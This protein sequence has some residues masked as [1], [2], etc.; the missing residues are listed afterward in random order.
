MSEGGQEKKEMS[1]MSPDL[2]MQR[3]QQP[4]GWHVGRELA[5]YVVSRRNYQPTGTERTFGGS[6]TASE[7]QAETVRVLAFKT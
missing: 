6:Q 7:R 4:K 3:M 5:S 1:I 2:T